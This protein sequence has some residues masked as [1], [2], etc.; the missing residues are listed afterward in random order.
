MPI[1]R[2]KCDQCR[3][4]EE[5]HREM[6]EETPV[7]HLCQALIPQ[8]YVHDVE[9]VDDNDILQMTTTPEAV[10]CKGTLKRKYDGFHFHISGR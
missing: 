5:I 6:S 1:Y 10:H 4:T 2:F 9:W 8:M 3:R 7:D